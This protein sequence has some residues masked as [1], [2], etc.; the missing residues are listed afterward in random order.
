MSRT[1]AKKLVSKYFK[2]N[3]FDFTSCEYQ[4]VA[5]VAIYSSI[6]SY[7]TTF[8]FAYPNIELIS[9]IHPEHYEDHK[10]TYLD[11]KDVIDLAIVN[12]NIPL[13]IVCDDFLIYLCNTIYMIH[14][15]YLNFYF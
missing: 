5:D 10:N 6:N 12:N 4:V 8:P 13:L 11:I 15:C 14:Q 3:K 1:G 2:N 7:A 9:E